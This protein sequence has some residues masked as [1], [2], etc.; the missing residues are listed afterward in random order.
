MKRMG[1]VWACALLASAC[2]RGGEN[3]GVPPEK[4]ADYVHAVIAADRATYAEEVVHRLQDVEKVARATE[5][6]REEKGL[7]LPSQMLRMGA[8][9][10]AK[11]GGFRYA[12]I[13]TWAINK[14]NMPRTDFETRGLDA[15]GKSPDVPYRSQEEVGG[16]RYFMSL[17][18]D[19]A[20]SEACVSCHNGHP[21]SPRK[22]FKLNDVMGGV[23]VALPL[24]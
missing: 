4:V 3:T 18:P 11:E 17:Y 2:S 1:C 7:P 24:E 5:Q 19:K 6:F 20:V 12:L 16:R 9:R 23:V 22:D 15:L 14:A 8:Q 21:E 13:S 10:A